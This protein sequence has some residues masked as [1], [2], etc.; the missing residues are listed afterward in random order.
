MLLDRR[1]RLGHGKVFAL[2]VVFYTFGRFWIESLRIDAVNRV[3]GFRLNNYTSLIVFVIAVALVLVAREEPAGPR[4]GGRTAAGPGGGGVELRS[5]E[6]RG[7]SRRR[8]ATEDREL[9]RESRTPRTTGGHGRHTGHESG[10]SGDKTSQTISDD[11][12]GSR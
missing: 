12:K 1:F 4:G 11:S 6:P 7:P 3:G 9:G 10:H 5:T 2:Y 8:T